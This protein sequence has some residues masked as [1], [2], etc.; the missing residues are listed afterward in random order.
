MND[1]FASLFQYHRDADLRF[2]DACR[3][4][5][6]EQ[7]AEPEPFEKGW[8]SIR[9]IVVHLAG[10]NDIWAR[11]LLGESP[12][13][14]P[15]EAD[16]PSLDSASALLMDAHDRFANPILPAMTPERLASAWT[17]RNCSGV[18]FTTPL[19]AVLRHLVNHGTYH[20]GQ[21]ASKLSRKGITPPVT[22][23]V[24][25]VVESTPQPN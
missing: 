12:M 1:D 17:Y 18:T 7:Y 22:D 10:G 19:W 14:R 21:L 6:A 25:W 23:L 24:Y 9:S 15:T 13:S 8:P 20:R 3:K 5:S 4:L 11:R 16:L 2:L